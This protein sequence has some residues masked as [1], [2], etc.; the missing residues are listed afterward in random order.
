MPIEVPIEAA[1]DPEAALRKA[2]GRYR[3]HAIGN[4]QNATVRNLLGQIGNETFNKEDWQQVKQDFDNRGAYCGG[5]DNLMMD[6][7]VPIN[8]THLGN[9]GWEI[10]PPPAR[11]ATTQ[12]HRKTSGNFWLMPLIASS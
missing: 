2:R 11:R 1:P 6:H 7:I 3:S 8:Q 9:I 10:W 5:E 12:K 4:A